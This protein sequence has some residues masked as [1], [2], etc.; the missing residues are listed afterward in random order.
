[1][2]K[3][4][5]ELA[6]TKTIVERILTMTFDGI[7]RL[8]EGYDLG[9]SSRTLV[10]RFPVLDGP[11]TAPASVIVKRTANANF[12]PDISNEATWLFFN[13]WASLSFLEKVST[14]ERFAPTFYGGERSTGLFV[15]EDMG[16]GT[17]LDHLLLG[18]DL[19]AAEAG[20]IAYASMH[21]R[22]HALSMSKQ[23]EYLHIRG[24]LGSNTP[25]PVE[26]YDYTWLKPTL[27]T[28]AAQLNIAIQPG[29]DE[30]L[31]TLTAA[32]VNPGPFLGFMQ[33]DSCPDNSM[34]VDG[35]W[36]MLDFEGSHYGHV[37]LEGAYCRMPMPTC[38][39]VYHLPEGILQQAEAAYR[40]ELIK[41]CPEAGDDVL[42]AQGLVGA[43][44]TW[45]LSFHQFMRPLE[46]M[47]SKDR[48][49]VALSDRQRFLL[50][51]NSATQAS[52]KFNSMPAMGTM[53]RTMAK[54]LS[55][56]S[57]VVESLC[58]IRH[59]GKRKSL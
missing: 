29:I 55:E 41:G 58:V 57:R 47:L 54:K 25:L 19:K 6:S 14:S 1:M 51:L 33:A 49:L 20:L 39:C 28:L 45:A 24:A 46:K 15:M 10:R 16:D 9:G 31:E 3:D 40:A 43:C 26:S 4:G 27:H 21:G 5:S 37:L 34:L 56:L 53:T 7:V 35:N 13:D 42:F 52:E 8:G 22:L 59:F 17:R 36:R 48:T 2:V 23:D 18:N 11:A 32:L 12:D 30:E 38:W 44:I 50:Y